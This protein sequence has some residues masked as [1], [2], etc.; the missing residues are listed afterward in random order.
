MKTSQAVRT[1]G[2]TPSSIYKCSLPSPRTA[3][4]LPYVWSVS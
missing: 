1:T 4:L 3:A 2:S